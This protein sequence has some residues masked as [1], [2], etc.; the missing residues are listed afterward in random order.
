MI[1]QLKI[2]LTPL[3]SYFFGGE[4]IFGFGKENIHYYIRS[5]NTP[6]QSALFGALRYIGIQDPDK[7]FYLNE[8]DISQIG[9][10]SF[11]LVKKEDQNFGKICSISP[12]YLE[13]KKGQ[14]LIRTPYDHDLSVTGDSYKRFEKYERITTEH[15]D[16]EYPVEYKAKEGLAD[17]WMELN[18]K[19]II[20]NDELFHAHSQTIVNKKERDQSYAKKEYKKLESGFA[21]VFYATVKD[22]FISHRKEV[23]LGQGKSPFSVDVKE[24]TEPAFPVNLLRDGI[25]YTQSDVYLEESENI[26]E[27]YDMCY[28]VGVKI[29]DFRVFTTDYSAGTVKDRYKKEA[30]IILVEAGSVFRPKDIRMFAEKLK[31]DRAKVAGFNIIQIG[32]GNIA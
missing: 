4:R 15:G 7:G 22:D 18:S 21:F 17:S 23:F 3:E 25:V 9:K 5:L 14:L 8:E 11:H 13:N 16:R 20:K 30:P 6:S 1:K 28:F 32:G 2:K 24:D 19:T 26:Q 29:R 10:K 12:L 31:N 27:L